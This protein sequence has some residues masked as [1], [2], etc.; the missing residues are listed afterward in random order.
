M[1]E[2]FTSTDNPE[3]ALKDEL[4]KS[5]DQHSLSQADKGKLDSRRDFSDF[6]PNFK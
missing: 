2:R 5:A 4:R 1:F 3:Q 6:I